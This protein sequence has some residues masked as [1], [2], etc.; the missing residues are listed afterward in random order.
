[1]QVL[2]Q[3]VLLNMEGCCG[4]RVQ[5]LLSSSDGCCFQENTTYTIASSHTSMPSTGVVP[6][7][8]PQP[9]VSV[10]LLKP[11]S[12]DLSAPGGAR[13]V[14]K[15]AGRASGNEGS[16]FFLA[17]RASTTCRVGD[18]SDDRTQSRRLHR[19]GTRRMSCHNFL[20][21]SWF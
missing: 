20:N 2:M 17:K 10:H 15:A 18:K 5:L 8:Q 9:H 1:M 12:M 21:F 13:V 16:H 6:A 19:G 11:D 14:M 7:G 3:H 4:L